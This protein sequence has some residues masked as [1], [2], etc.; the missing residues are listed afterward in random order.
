MRLLLAIVALVA[1]AAAAEAE[2]YQ[3]TS[4]AGCTARIT[5]DGVV[6]EHSFRK[7]DI[8]STE[9]G[10]V[11]SSG[12]GWVKL[13]TKDRVQGPPAPA[14]PKPSAFVYSPTLGGTVQ[15][16]GTLFGGPQAFT[17]G[18][19]AGSDDTY[20][21]HWKHDSDGP[22]GVYQPQTVVVKCEKRS[23]ETVREHANRF[24]GMV[25]AMRE[26]FPPNVPE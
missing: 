9:A 20:E 26:L 15:V 7:N 1:T 3:C 24:K 16:G 18:S 19:G 8:V 13:K 6:E 5:V 2:E 11:V 22:G 10:W 25:D 14:A 17:G 4:D 12:C 23:G 21:M